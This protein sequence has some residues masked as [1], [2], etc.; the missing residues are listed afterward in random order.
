[1]ESKKELSGRHFDNNDDVAVARDHLL[2]VQDNEFC[3]EQS[4]GSMCAG[5]SVQM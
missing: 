4:G 5:L 1:M 2:E 3:K